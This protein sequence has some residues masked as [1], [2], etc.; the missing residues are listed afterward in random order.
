VVKDEKV[1]KGERKRMEGGT[2]VDWT[3]ERGR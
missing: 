2:L 1:M 3:V